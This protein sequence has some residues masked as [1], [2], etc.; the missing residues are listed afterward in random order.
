MIG[1]YKRG[2]CWPSMTDSEI[3]SQGPSFTVNGLA[4][5]TEVEEGRSSTSTRVPSVS[6]WMAGNMFRTYSE[7]LKRGAINVVRRIR[8]RRPRVVHAFG[9]KGALVPFLL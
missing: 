6:T 9:F 4:R 3:V 2:P 8:A 1:G 5:K 7:S